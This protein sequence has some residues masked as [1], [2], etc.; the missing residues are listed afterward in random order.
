MHVE[1]AIKSKT[2]YSLQNN[3]M[4]LFQTI[5]ETK[6]WSLCLHPLL[7]IFLQMKFSA[8]EGF[9][10][11]QMLYDIIHTFVLTGL[12]ISYVELTDCR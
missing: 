3:E 5:T 12:A 2:H 7:Q 11:L 10:Y 8:I 1:Y 9:F 4:A 6:K